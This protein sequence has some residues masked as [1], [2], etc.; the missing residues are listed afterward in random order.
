[1]WVEEF[2]WCNCD[3]LFSYKSGRLCRIA[4][5]KPGRTHSRF[6]SANTANTAI[7][8]WKARGT[9]HNDY[10]QKGITINAN[11]ISTYWTRSVK[12]KQ[13]YLAKKI[14]LF[15]KAKHAHMCCSYREIYQIT[16]PIY[17]SSASFFE[18]IP[19][20]WSFN[21]LAGTHIQYAV[22]MEEDV[23]HNLQ[24]PPNLS[25]FFRS[26]LSKISTRMIELKL[27]RLI[28]SYFIICYDT[29]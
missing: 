29:L 9:I 22:E 7:D 23:E 18:F 2:A 24:M 8:F 3:E 27:G 15:H 19:P 13:L 14:V 1:M 16:I 6:L 26:S 21:V 10:L 25:S 11:N 4:S 17:P 5:C 28:C 20:F 12:K